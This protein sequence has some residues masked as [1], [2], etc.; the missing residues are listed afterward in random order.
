MLILSVNAAERVN[1]FI[2]ARVR[3][4][5]LVGRTVKLLYSLDGNCI[6]CPFVHEL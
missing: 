2:N 1:S 6:F 5:Q 4:L 3:K